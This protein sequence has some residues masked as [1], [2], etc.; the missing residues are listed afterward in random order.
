MLETA[1]NG[2][3]GKITNR[4]KQNNTLSSSSPYP[5]PE[6]EREGERERERER[7]MS[8]VPENGHVHHV[9]DS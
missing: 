6:R 9:G 3:I 1:E 2:Q 7:V 4:Q 5:I 8:W